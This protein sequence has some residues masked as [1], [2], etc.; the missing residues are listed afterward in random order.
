MTTEEYNIKIKEL[1]KERDFHQKE[2]SRLDKEM[3]ELV[4]SI[5]K[6]KIDW[7]IGKYIKFD[8]RNKG[9]Y[10]GFFHVNSIDTRPRGYTLYGKGFDISNSI[11]RI[12]DTYYD[13][14]APFPFYTC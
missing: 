4:N 12:N 6:E 10:L 3:D 9:Q 11:I 13:F 8:G 14:N 5:D 2:A 7:M 1:R